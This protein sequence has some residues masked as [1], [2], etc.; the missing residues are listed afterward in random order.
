MPPP[1]R[2]SRS[3][4]LHRSRPLGLTLLV[5]AGAF[6]LM[7]AADE[8]DDT[9]E[10]LRIE[11]AKRFSSPDDPAVLERRDRIEMLFARTSPD[12]AEVLYEELG[13]EDN[14][15]ELS[16]AFHYALATPTRKKLREMLAFVF[17]DLRKMR[18]EA[19]KLSD[20]EESRELVC[21]LDKLG[22]GRA[23]DDRVIQWKTLQESGDPLPSLVQGPDDVDAIT[24]ER[25]PLF[26]F[27]GAVFDL[28]AIDGKGISDL[29]SVRE[30]TWEAIRELDAQ[31]ASLPP[32]LAAIRGWIEQQRSSPSSVMSC[33]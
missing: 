26:T 16:H 33:L 13:P 20:P 27:V 24:P 14:G 17:T 5:L 21:W 23:T 18:G 2:R 4:R 28:A 30:G 10:A 19:E 6:P 31:A 12:C 29:R 32:H 9:R 11:L 7:A 22:A 8:C 25:Y 15:D 1:S 3:L